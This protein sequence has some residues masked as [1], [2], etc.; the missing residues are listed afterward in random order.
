LGCR[1]R[2]DGAG[3]LASGP[4]LRRVKAA[5]ALAVGGE[6][7]DATLVVASG[8]RQ[9]DGHVEADVMAR[10]LVCLGVRPEAIVK[11]RLSMTTRENARFVA[12]SLGR[13]KTQNATVVTCEWHLERA[14]MLFRRT[15]LHVN[16]F[17]VKEPAPRWDR[18][19]WLWGREHALL[20]VQ[21]H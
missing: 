3:R 17:P 13:R 7:R 21:G 15:G 11:E 20:W 10:E 8:G 18:Q 2:L 16:G 12:E 14:L 6:N 1:V 4:L 19:A 5:A 9:W